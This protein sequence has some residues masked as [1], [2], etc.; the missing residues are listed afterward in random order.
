MEN[1]EGTVIGVE[2]TAIY[3]KFSE[4]LATPLFS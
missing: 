3:K 2:R 1:V 4:E